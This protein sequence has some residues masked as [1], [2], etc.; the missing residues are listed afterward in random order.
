MTSILNVITDAVRTAFA[1]AGYDAELGRVSISNRPDLCEYQSNGAMAG[2]KQY[3]KKPIDIA[4]DVVIKLKEM[5]RDEL[6]LFSKA[7]A[8]MPGF[9]NLDVSGEYLEKYLNEMNFQPDLGLDVH[10][11]K[12]VVVDYGGANVAK[13]LHVGHLRSAVIGESVKRI[14][15]FMGDR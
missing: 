3:H 10:E 6:Y 13:P 12:K 1:L 4:N 8:V 7:E 2:A 5:K 11:G 15:K 14:G 9:I